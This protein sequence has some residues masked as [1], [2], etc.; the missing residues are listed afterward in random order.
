MITVQ[1]NYS[2]RCV[3]GDHLQ[4]AALERAISN[5]FLL[6][7]HFCH[8]ILLFHIICPYFYIAWPECALI[9]FLQ[10]SWAVT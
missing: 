5:A 6:H 8:L 4:G 10:Q 1:A 2:Q 7:I 9:A 3:P